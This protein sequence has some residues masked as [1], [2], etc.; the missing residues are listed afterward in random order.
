KRKIPD[1]IRTYRVVLFILALVIFVGNIIPAGIDIYTLISD[2]IPRP[3][4]VPL[5]SVLYTFSASATAL[6]SSILIWVLYNLARSEPA[7]RDEQELAESAKL[8]RDK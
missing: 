5:M 3:D 7:N 2:T 6:V 1:H 4:R 8:I